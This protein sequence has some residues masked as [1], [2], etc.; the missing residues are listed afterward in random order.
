MIEDKNSKSID[1]G[2]ICRMAFPH[3]QYS[4]EE[5]GLEQKLRGPGGEGAICEF[6]ETAFTSTKE[7]NKHVELDKQCRRARRQLRRKVRERVKQM[8]SAD[9]D[10][11]ISMEEEDERS[12]LQP[13]RIKINLAKKEVVTS[14]KNENT[15]QVKAARSCVQLETKAVERSV[16][17][18]V[19]NIE[20]QN[21]SQSTQVTSLSKT[22]SPNST[23]M[24]RIKEEILRDVNSIKSEPVE[25]ASHA[26][27]GIRVALEKKKGRRYSV[28]FT[29]SLPP[30]QEGSD[31][32]TVGDKVSKK[33]R[34]S[35][36]SQSTTDEPASKYT[37]KKS[38]KQGNSEEANRSQKKKCK[39]MERYTN[40]SPRGDS[41]KSEVFHLA[42]GTFKPVL[43]DHLRGVWVAFDTSFL[44]DLNTVLCFRLTKDNQV[45]KS[46]ILLF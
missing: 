16:C 5:C 28:A 39:N 43:P 46:H 17:E 24:V 30:T 38:E 40:D 45:N 2:D 6:C 33:E 3:H 4:V 18:R 21:W 36:K 29:S 42:E 34:H 32:T 27:S 37:K 41:E 15:K 9:D 7:C 11:G 25:D 35:Y 14:H 1:H 20:R 22:F 44:A 26:A 8:A 31:Q 23:P 13:L 10:S 12:R 19:P